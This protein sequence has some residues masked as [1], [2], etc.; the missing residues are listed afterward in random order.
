M[1][2]ISP[3]WR[4]LA[5]QNYLNCSVRNITDRS[6]LPASFWL[7]CSAFTEKLPIAIT[8]QKSIVAIT[9]F[10]FF[11]LFFFLRLR[12]LFPSAVFPI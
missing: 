2:R 3:Q 9:S 5:V 11:I 8:S 12:Q 4:I 6:L 10:L 1:L 7:S